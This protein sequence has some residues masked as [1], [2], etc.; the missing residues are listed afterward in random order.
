[1]QPGWFWIGLI[2]SCL[3]GSAA[4]ADSLIDRTS[5]AP[6][7]RGLFVPGE[8]DTSDGMSA[9]GI[10][11]FQSPG[12]AEGR[13]G[14]AEQ[15]S[16][17]LESIRDQPEFR[18]LR[19][20]KPRPVENSELP[21]WLKD[22]WNWLTT[23]S[24]SSTDTPSL[25]F[26]GG[27]FQVLAYA[28]IAAIC[29][30][31]IWLLVKAV[32]NYRTRYS[33]NSRPQK[34]FEEGET[35]LPPGDLPS[36]EYLRRAGEYAERGMIREAIGQLILG[37]MS[38]IERG[39]LIRFRRGL[40]HRDYLRAVRTRLVAHRA[41]RQIVAVYEPIC[42]GRRSAAMEHYLSS[43]DDYK[44]GFLQSFDEPAATPGNSPPAG[45]ILDGAQS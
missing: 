36:D 27:V 24:D 23:S 8:N 10:I 35:G 17:E 32:Q 40:T 30:A 29:A 28:V 12:P 1:M 26:L 44:F 9:E 38:R 33:Q 34:H 21:Q 16:R 3:A 22:F 31:I 6:L 25:S 43:L 42:F 39:K 37:A 4:K 14:D 11:A 41:F 7:S 15:I 2:V 18:R 20:E 13:F 45:A 19:K 5:S